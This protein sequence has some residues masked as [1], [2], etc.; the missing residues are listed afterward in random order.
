MKRGTRVRFAYLG[1]VVVIETKRTM[2]AN[3]TYLQSVISHGSYAPG[4]VRSETMHNFYAIGANAAFRRVELARLLLLPEYTRKA[5]E[6]ARLYKGGSG[7][8]T[9]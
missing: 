8:H 1:Y 9:M 2:P 7:S 4:R 6:Q 3:K 5:V